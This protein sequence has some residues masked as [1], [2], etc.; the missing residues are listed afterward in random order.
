MAEEDISLS[1]SAS[2]PSAPQTQ[3]VLKSGWQRQTRGVEN[4][5]ARGMCVAPQG[6]T[7]R[8]AKPVRAQPWAP[9]ARNTLPSGH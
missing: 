5:R 2:A 8:K 1:V 3:P 9:E 6:M 7:W 4:P